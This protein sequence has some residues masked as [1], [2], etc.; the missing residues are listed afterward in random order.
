MNPLVHGAEYTVLRQ[1]LTDKHSAPNE[2]GAPDIL[3]SDVRDRILAS[4]AEPNRRLFTRYMP[5]LPPDSYT[6]E[7]ATFDLGNVLSQPAAREATVARRLSVAAVERANR[8]S[9]ALQR[10]VGRVRRLERPRRT[11]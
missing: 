10:T 1:F 6:D 7:V 4:Y 3:P 8:A 2:Y 9:T 5:D 11:G